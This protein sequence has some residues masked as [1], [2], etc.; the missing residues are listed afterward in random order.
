M[1]SIKRDLSIPRH[2]TIKGTPAIDANTSQRGACFEPRPGYHSIPDSPLGAYS[3]QI[4]MHW[5]SSDITKVITAAQRMNASPS[6]LNTAAIEHAILHA[7]IMSPL[8]LVDLSH[9]GVGTTCNANV[10]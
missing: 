9:C 5:D 2:G 10:S 8:L 3:G 4:H 1:I 7:P 6:M